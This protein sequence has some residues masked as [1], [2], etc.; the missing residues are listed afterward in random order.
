VR[1]GTPAIT[2][3]G[4]KEEHMDAVADWFHRAVRNAAE[5]QGGDERL[6]VIAREVREFLRDFPAPGL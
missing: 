3:R 5:T 2:S 1:L 6:D 4:L